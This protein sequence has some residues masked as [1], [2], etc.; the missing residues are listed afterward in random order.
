MAKPKT[1]HLHIQL[2]TEEMT[3][4]E[5]YTRGIYGAKNLL[6]RTLL[7]RFFKEQD[8]YEQKKEVSNENKIKQN[9]S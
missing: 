7:K 3:T 2:T 5:Q 8:T 9:D 1:H 4:L 6:V